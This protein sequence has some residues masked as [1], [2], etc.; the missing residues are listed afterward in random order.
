VLGFQDEVWRSRLARPGL[1]AWTD[2][3]P[4]RLH[5]PPAG[6]DDGDP[7]APAC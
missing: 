2:G 7:K 6:A 4:M 3:D 1:R 5:E